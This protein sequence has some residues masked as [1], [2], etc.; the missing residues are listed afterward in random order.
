MDY[1]K[2]SLALHKEAGGKFKTTA[3]VQVENRE[4]LCLAYTPGVAEP[5]RAIAE[6][7]K[8]SFVYTSRG[9]MVA[10]ISDGTAVLGLGNIG[11]EAAMPVMEGKA[12][13]F[14]KFADI[15]SVPLCINAKSAD[16]IIAFC[17]MIAPSFAGINLEDIASPVCFEVEK[18]LERRLDIP[19]FHDD[20]HGTAIVVMAALVSAFRLTGRDFASTKIVLSGPGA[21]G[22]AIIEMLYILGA[23]NILACDEGGIL[24]PS[25][26]LVP[27][28]AAIAGRTNS[29]DKNGTLAEAMVGAD[30]FIGV[31][32][33]GIVTG[34]MV[35]GMAR[36][37]I[38]F[39]MANP[40]PE[41]TYHEAKNAGAAVA[42]TGRSDTPNQINNLLAFPGIFR[43]ALDCGA[44]HIT[45][46]MKSAAVYAI[47]DIVGE[48]LSP[49]Y[50]IPDVFDKRVVEAVAKAVAKAATR[51]GVIR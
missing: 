42:G 6:D 30:V 18:E 50:I 19:V 31:S 3:K 37:A 16:E 2:Q 51:D 8:N 47:A 48:A 43:G 5:C 12:L 23:N 28:K 38:V 1:Y 32:A 27:H 9:N 35:R 10:V 46:S 34:E 20:Q 17:E 26:E 7:G 14:H 11:P 24:S 45:E 39:A 49:E 21:A 13:L 41:I 15:D 44:T 29:A 25:R 4:Q 40:V 33:P 36:D 22:N